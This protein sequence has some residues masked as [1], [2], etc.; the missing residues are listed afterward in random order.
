MKKKKK[1]LFLYFLRNL[2]KRLLETNGN[3]SVKNTGPLKNAKAS[4]YVFVW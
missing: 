1:D 2:T 4:L 3:A